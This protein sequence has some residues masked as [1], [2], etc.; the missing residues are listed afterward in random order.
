MITQPAGHGRFR[1]RP[2]QLKQQLQQQQPSPLRQPWVRRQPLYLLPQAA[3]CPST[4]VPPHPIWT[5][6]AALGML[7]I[8]RSSAVMFS[9]IAVPAGSG[10]TWCMTAQAVQAVQAVH[11]TPLLSFLMFPS[12]SHLHRASCAEVW[13]GPSPSCLPAPLTC[14][15][16]LVLQCGGVLLLHGRPHVVDAARQPPQ[17]GLHA[18]A[19][20]CR[21]GGGQPVDAA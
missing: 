14:N 9:M 2:P 18:A 6:V 5:F 13:R 21:R 4:P 17:A 11:V 3:Q 19:N 20:A 1:L 10:R 15:V 16:H 7:R 8:N 12:P